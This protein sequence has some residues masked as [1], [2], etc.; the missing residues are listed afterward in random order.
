MIGL[1]YFL[2]KDI[3]PHF[4]QGKNISP[5]EF[6]PLNGR[7]FPLKGKDLYLYEEKK[8][9]TAVGKNFFPKREEILP[10]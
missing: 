1:P 3:L 6:F 9:K 2:G 10:F 5:R 4:T 7:I 8:N